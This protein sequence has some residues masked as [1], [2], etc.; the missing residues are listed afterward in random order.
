VGRRSSGLAHRSRSPLS[1]IWFH[2]LRYEDRPASG[3]HSL[4]SAT[5]LS[6]PYGAIGYIGLAGATAGAAL[7]I[8]KAP[9][10]RYIRWPLAFTYI[11][12]PTNIAVIARPYTLL[13]LLAFAAAMLFKDSTIP[14]AW[15]VLVLLANLKLARHNP[16][17]LFRLSFI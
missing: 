1:T 11:H 12:G 15:C 8:F 13:P 7:L 14:N 6:R 2:E 10:P 17:R 9:F 5:R 16:R 4:D 3:T